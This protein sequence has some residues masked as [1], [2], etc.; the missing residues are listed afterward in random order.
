MSG[1]E[2]GTLALQPQK[3]VAVMKAGRGT[4]GTVERC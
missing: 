2:A 4:E 3:F 1:L